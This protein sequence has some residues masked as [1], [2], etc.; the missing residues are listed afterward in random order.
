M[1]QTRPAPFPDLPIKPPKHAPKEG[2]VIIRYDV[3]D[4][5]A[6]CCLC[7]DLTPVGWVAVILL[8]VFFFPF[9][10]IPCCIRDC[11]ESVSE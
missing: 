9:A 10:W 8:L 4:G 3:K 5:Q 11:H 6:G 7:G 1:Q 2:H